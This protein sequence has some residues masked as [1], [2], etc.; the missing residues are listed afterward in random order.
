MI[1]LLVQQSILRLIHFGE[2]IM[3]ETVLDNQVEQVVFAENGAVFYIFQGDLLRVDQGKKVR[4]LP[5]V[6]Y[7]WATR[8]K[9]EEK[10]RIPKFMMAVKVCKA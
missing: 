3:E 9:L 2:D 5:K 6:S 10:C 8:K 4:M 1:R 7:V